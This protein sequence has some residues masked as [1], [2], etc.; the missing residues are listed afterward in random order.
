MLILSQNSTF[1]P[2]LFLWLFEDKWREWLAVPPFTVCGW[3]AR[4]GEP[5]VTSSTL[6]MGGNTI[7][8]EGERALLPS[9]I[10]SEQ[11][12]PIPLIT[13]R[14]HQSDAECGI[15]REQCLKHQ[16]SFN[17]DFDAKMYPVSEWY[18]TPVWVVHPS[19]SSDQNTPLLWVFIESVFVFLSVCMLLCICPYVVSLVPRRLQGSALA[20]LSQGAGTTHTSRAEKPPSSSQMSLKEDP[21]RASCSKSG[22]PLSSGAPSTRTLLCYCGEPQLYAS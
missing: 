1:Q 17:T 9:S 6:P 4:R 22:G 18:S 8:A 10:R 13:G 7:F 5:G 21:R 20:S 16:V 11:S 12:N 19:Q 2:C 15:S 3:V 14:H